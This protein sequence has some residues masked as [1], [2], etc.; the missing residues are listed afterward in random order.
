MQK[1]IVLVTC[2]TAVAAPLL[3]NDADQFPR[4]AGLEGDIS[5]WRRIFGEIHSDQALLH[6]NR[7]LSVV[8]E[9]V[10]IPPN[11][12]SRTRH[13][14]ADKA[15]DRYRKI[16]RTLATGK[17]SGLSNEEQRDRKSVV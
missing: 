14:V 1:L 8:Y 4:P 11:A 2:L 13:K 7:N 15:R 6:D 12:S 9:T 10:T 5:F 3:A 17:R 16:L